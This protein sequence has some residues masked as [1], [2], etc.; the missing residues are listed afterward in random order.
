MRVLI[1]SDSH[2]YNDILMNILDNIQCDC[3]VHCGDSI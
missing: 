3:I 2:M 1:L